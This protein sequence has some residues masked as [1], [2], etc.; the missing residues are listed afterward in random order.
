[1]SVT[2]RLHCMIVNSLSICARHGTSPFNQ[3]HVTPSPCE[4]PVSHLAYLL[5]PSDLLETM[6]PREIE[7]RGVLGKDPALECP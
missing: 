4:R 3:N 2:G 5:S 6:L 1:V 7:T